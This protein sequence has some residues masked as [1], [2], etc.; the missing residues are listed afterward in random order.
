MDLDRFWAARAIVGVAVWLTA[1]TA[2]VDTPRLTAELKAVRGKEWLTVE[3]ARL[4]NY[5]LDWIDARV[6]AGETV[7]TMNQ[8]LKAAGLFPRVAGGPGRA[9][10]SRAG[11]PAV[12][13][14]A[15]G[16]PRTI[17]CAGRGDDAGVAGRMA[18]GTT[19]RLPHDANRIAGAGRA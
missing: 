2:A 16:V 15:A 8:E 5:Y 12:R 10:R 11:L 19:G 14:V 17:L 1:A 3:Y 6:R 7:G 18:R 13:R 9:G 4:Q